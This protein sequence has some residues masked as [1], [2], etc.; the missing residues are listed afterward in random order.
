MAKSHALSVRVAESSLDDASLHAPVAL[1][2]PSLLTHFST[3]VTITYYKIAHKPGL[4][5]SPQTS[6]KINSCETEKTKLR[7]LKFVAR[8]LYT[9]DSQ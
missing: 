8:K 7:S 2:F 4:H 3:A 1:S 6:T 5:E 9:Y